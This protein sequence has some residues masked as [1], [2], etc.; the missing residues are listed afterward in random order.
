MT[1]ASN[2]KVGDQVV[3]CKNFNA[4]RWVSYLK[5]KKLN[6]HGVFTVTGYSKLR[7]LLEFKEVPDKWYAC[8]Y[9]HLKCIDLDGDDDD[10]I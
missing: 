6:P 7:G 2:F 10:C 4:Q 3:R 1:N 8:N 5:S 9:E